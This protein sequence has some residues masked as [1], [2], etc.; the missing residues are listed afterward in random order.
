MAD[1]PQS[2][3][4]SMCSEENARLLKTSF[5]TPSQSWESYHCTLNVSAFDLYFWPD[6]ILFWA[7]SL[8]KKQSRC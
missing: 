3:P 4:H 5:P 7:L 6:G 8:L 2:W 1:S